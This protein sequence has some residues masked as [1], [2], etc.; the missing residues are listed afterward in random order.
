M[1]G[2]ANPKTAMKVVIFF[3][4]WFERNVLEPLACFG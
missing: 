4:P 3:G 2:K 1:R